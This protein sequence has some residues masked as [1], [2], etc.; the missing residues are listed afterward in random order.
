MFDFKKR[1]YNL[2]LI[3]AT[4]VLISSF[5]VYKQ[6]FDMHINDTYFVLSYTLLFWPIIILLMVF[7][8]LYLVTKN[9]LFSNILTWTHSILLVLT[10]ISLAL[11]LFYSNY[12]AIAGTPR[13]YYDFSNWE[14][15]RH[16]PGLVTG[17][18]LVAVAKISGLFLFITNVTL[19]LIKRYNERK[20][21]VL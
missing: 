21:S 7:W 3:T 9:F 6:S 15:V 13:Q 4:L 18:L 20:N 16:I 8:M 2:L 1:P 10:S 17:F 5:I 12:Q 14:T 11:I 19:G